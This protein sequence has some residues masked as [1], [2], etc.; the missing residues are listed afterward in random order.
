VLDGELSPSYGRSYDMP[1]P[2]IHKLFAQGR[3]EFDPVKR[4][5]IYDD[6]QKQALADAPMVTLA[7][8]LQSYAM[9]TRL[10]GF[11]S[12][13]GALSGNSG[14]TLETSELV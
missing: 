8:R 6:L 1:T 7:W 10:Q 14:I 11:T 13:P 12:I 5:A 2:E 9:S 4:R 3:S